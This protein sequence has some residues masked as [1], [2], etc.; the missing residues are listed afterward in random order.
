MSP[1]VEMSSF[2]LNSITEHTYSRLSACL[3]VSVLYINS[4]YTVSYFEVHCD[5]G[6][7]EATREYFNTYHEAQ[8]Y[9]KSFDDWDDVRVDHL[10]INT[11]VLPF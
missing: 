6:I 1:L 11:D 8:A 9:A 10:Q 4:M 7:P 2:P 3:L 5:D